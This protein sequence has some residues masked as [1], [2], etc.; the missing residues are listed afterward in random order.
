MFNETTENTLETTSELALVPVATLP[1]RVSKRERAL[2]ERRPEGGRRAKPYRHS[3]PVFDRQVRVYSEYVRRLVSD[4]QLKPAMTALYGIDLILRLIATEAEIDR[5][6]QAIDARLLEVSEAMAD[7]LEVLNA[8]L[9][10]HHLTGVCPRYTEEQELRIE[11]SSP[12]IGA[13][14]NLIVEL[15]QL[16]IAIDTLWLS[17]LMS[18]QRHV[19]CLT[20]WRDRLGLVG[21]AFVALH[22][23]ADD[24][25]DR[26]GQREAVDRTEPHA[27]L[28]V[29]GE[30]G[31]DAD[32][33]AE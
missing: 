6:D 31:E 20:Q 18:N 27:V 7:E 29:I 25:A 11:V 32:T 2:A 4:R 3:R 8:Q 33:L 12:P 17:G 24:E 14:T 22:R 30:D 21:Q 13:Y 26:R 9:A 1:A 16:M 23:A 5:I 15:D 10:R 28:T 19:E